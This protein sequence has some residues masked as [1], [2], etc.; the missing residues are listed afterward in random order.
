MEGEEV[1]ILEGREDN[2]TTIIRIKIIKKTL[3]L[4]SHK[5][6]PKMIK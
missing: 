4:D 6:H 2:I 5:I 1:I 3:P